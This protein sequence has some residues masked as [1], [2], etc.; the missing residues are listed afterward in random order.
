MFIQDMPV[1]SRLAF[2]TIGDNDI[3]WAKVSDH[4]DFFA[5]SSCAYYCFDYPEWRNTTRGRRTGGNNFYPHSNIAQWLNARGTNWFQAAHSFD[6]SPYWAFDRGFLTG[7]TD[8][9]IDLIQP[10][11]VKVVVPVG[12]RKE[13]GREY[14]YT[15]K[16]LLPSASQIGCVDA[17]IGNAEGQ[18]LF[19]PAGCFRSGMPIV[20][21]RTGCKGSGRHIYS[22]LGGHFAVL[23]AGDKTVVHP[24]IRLGNAQVAPPRYENRLYRLI[25]AD[26]DFEARFMTL[27]S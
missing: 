3:I 24:M 2:G 18:K 1:G 11:T 14:A 8:H 13:F 17:E 15:A 27:V 25:D 16:V 23:S 26:D 21:T 12:S 7:F 20:M 5:V 19:D 4:N 10:Q 6:E 9:E 22:Y